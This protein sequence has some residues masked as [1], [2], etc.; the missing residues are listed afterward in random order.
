LVIATE[1]AAEGI[2]CKHEEN[3]L[4]HTKETFADAVTKSLENEALQNRIGENARNFV[5]DQYDFIKIA[6]DAL[7]FIK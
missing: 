7:N 4:I 5:A 2:E 6:S 1:I 3:I